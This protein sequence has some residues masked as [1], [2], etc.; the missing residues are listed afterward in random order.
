[1]SNRLRSRN[2]AVLSTVLVA[3]IGVSACGAETDATTNQDRGNNPGQ[4]G[5]TPG[6]GKFKM[7]P[8]EAH[9]EGPDLVIT[10]D[11]GNEVITK[12]MPD[13]PICRENEQNLPPH[14]PLS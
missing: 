8:G 4:Y 9:C 11:I 12:R 5:G 7:I 14:S 3:S 6:Q 2:I 13:S 1:M 10:I